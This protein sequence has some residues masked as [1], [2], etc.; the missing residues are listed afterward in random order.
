MIEYLR[1]ILLGQFEACLC[2]LD[3]CVRKCPPGQWDDK[4]ANGTFR[5]IAYHTLYHIDLYLSPNAETFERTRDRRWVGGERVGTE[6]CAGLTVDDTLSYLTFCRHKAVE[7][8]AAETPDSLQARAEFD[9]LSLSRGELHLYNIR[10]IQHHT[11]QLS[12]YL[13]RVTGS[14]EDWWIDSGWL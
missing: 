2:M 9:W 8:L 6:T 4:V 1:T 13:R 14:R 3:R 12:G 5:Q 7:T 10:H 11:G